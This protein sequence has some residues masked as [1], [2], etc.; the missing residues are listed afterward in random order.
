MQIEFFDNLG[1]NVYTHK[2]FLSKGNH[3]VALSSLSDLPMGI[4]FCKITTPT[5]SVSKK[6]QKV[7]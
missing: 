6:I 5:W 7:E 3:Q 1:R 2:Q 4:Y